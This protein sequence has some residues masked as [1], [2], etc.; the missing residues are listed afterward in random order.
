MWGSCHP[1]VGP[2]KPWIPVY[3]GTPVRAVGPQNLDWGFSWTLVRVTCR[4][5]AV[6]TLCVGWNLLGPT[7]SPSVPGKQRMPGWNERFR[8]FLLK[9]PHHLHPSPPQLC[10]RTPPSHASPAHPR[11]LGQPGGQNL[12]RC[13]TPSPAGALGKASPFYR[14]GLP[15]SQ[16]PG[17]PQ[18]VPDLPGPSGRTLPDSWT[19]TLPLSGP[20]LAGTAGCPNT[21][22]P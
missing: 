18:A 9:P 14:A 6:S 21:P 13:W 15:Q 16:T 4:L 17:S 11:G 20:H 8:C 2:P 7:G 22:R 19:Q 1:A 12:R 10:G 5:A 3:P